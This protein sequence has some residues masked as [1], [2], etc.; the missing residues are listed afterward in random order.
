MG[1]DNTLKDRLDSSRRGMHAGE[2]E[3]RR[4]TPPSRTWHCSPGS[5]LIYD[6]QLGDFGIGLETLSCILVNSRA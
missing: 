4:R 6:E 5:C 2:T 3:R 1:G